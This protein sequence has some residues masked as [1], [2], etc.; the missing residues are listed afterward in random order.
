VCNIPCD[1]HLEHLNRRLKGSLHNLGPNNNNDIIQH[2]AKTV[3]IVS[4]VCRQFE[5][6]T[7]SIKDS[8]HHNRKPYT[9]DFNLILEEKNVFSNKPDRMHKNFTL[10]QGHMQGFDIIKLRKWLEDEIEGIK[11]YY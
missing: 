7:G 3:G 5:R 1:L 8:D 2:A 6:E 10:T 9:Q 11:K 4:K